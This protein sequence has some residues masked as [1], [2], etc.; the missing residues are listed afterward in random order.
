MQVFL[1]IFDKKNKFTFQIRF[2]IMLKP[3]QERVKSVLIESVSLLCKNGLNFKCEL[4]VEGVIGITIDGGDIFVIHIDKKFGNEN[5]AASSFGGN[6]SEK[7]GNVVGSASSRGG[8]SSARGARG[9]RT[10]EPG[11]RKVRP[12]IQPSM[13]IKQEPQNV[14]LSPR[15]PTGASQRLPSANQKMT[16]GLPRVPSSNPRMNYS[17][18][19]QVSEHSGD[20]Q[21]WSNTNYPQA[22]YQGTGGL[23]VKQEQDNQ[24]SYQPSDVIFVN[25]DEGPVGSEV[26]QHTDQSSSDVPGGDRFSEDAGILE[27]A[28]AGNIVRSDITRVT[29]TTDA[30]GQNVK[31]IERVQSATMPVKMEQGMFGG[32]QPPEQGMFGG[33][34]GDYSTA[35]QSYMYGEDQPGNCEEE[36]YGAS[37]ADEE[38]NMQQQ[39][40]QQMEDEMAWNENGRMPSNQ[41]MNRRPPRG[42]AVSI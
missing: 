13:Q 30:Q 5:Q 6:T 32:C 34:A 36:E 40:E 23:Y 41:R 15:I 1:G 18:S 25:E 7:V 22:G 10:A 11:V 12:K 8:F 3:E 38:W 42:R 4:K 26:K 16:R 24:H 2:I 33:P 37:M 35:D 27:L 9:G 28:K 19:T 20:A 17:P 14:P 29:I 21:P 31:Q 39:Q